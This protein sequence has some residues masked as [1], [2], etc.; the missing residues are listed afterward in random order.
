M[1]N[2]HTTFLDRIL[3]SLRTIGAFLEDAGAPETGRRFCC[4]AAMEPG[5]PACDMPTPSSCCGVR[6]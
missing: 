4:G 5:C 6:V 2:R 3:G 1:E